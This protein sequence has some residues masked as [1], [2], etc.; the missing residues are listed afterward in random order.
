VVEVHCVSIYDPQDETDPNASSL[1]STS[2]SLRSLKFTHPEDSDSSSSET[3]DQSKKPQQATKLK[4]TIEKTIEISGNIDKFFEASLNP[5]VSSVLDATSSSERLTGL[6]NPLA[7]PNTSSGSS[8]LIR[9]IIIS[10]DPTENLSDDDDDPDDLKV[11]ATTP[12]RG[13]IT[14]LATEDVSP[15][16][17]LSSEDAVQS[18]D[19]ESF[20]ERLYDFSSSNAT[21][22]YNKPWNN[23]SSPNTNQ[24]LR[25]ITNR[26]LM[27]TLQKSEAKDLSSFVENLSKS[28]VIIKLASQGDKHN[29]TLKNLF[30]LKR[31]HSTT[32]LLDEPN[33][34]QHYDMFDFMDKHI[35]T[36]K[37]PKDSDQKEVQ[38]HSRN[39][40]N[41]HRQSHHNHDRPSTKQIKFPELEPL[42]YYF[43]EDDFE[44]IS[45]LPFHKKKHTRKKHSK[46]SRRHPHVMITTRDDP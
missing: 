12:G 11:A 36:M 17:S 40:K 21:R 2:K 13:K 38:A 4:A 16:P 42:D 23:N 14:T 37:N 29:N 24:A 27:S 1:I 3:Q 33:S 39:R 34:T 46:H 15:K 22:T 9:P 6:L 35:E 25:K 20:P 8:D 10:L 45:N 31:K 41:K 18:S 28:K 43:D 26:N 30:G 7:D 5:L 32:N 44:E 19:D